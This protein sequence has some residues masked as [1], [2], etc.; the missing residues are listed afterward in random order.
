ME[1]DISFGAIREENWRDF[2][3]EGEYKKKI[4]DLRWKIYVKEEEDLIKR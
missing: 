3:D 2:S 4:H 1:E